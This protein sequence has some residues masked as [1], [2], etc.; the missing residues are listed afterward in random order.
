MRWIVL[1]VLGL[2][3]AA[4]TQAP[5][6]GGNPRLERFEAYV[7][8]QQV[9]AR[10]ATAV[11]ATRWA[12]R[13]Q[14]YTPKPP[15]RFAGR[16]IIAG[17]RGDPRIRGSRGSGGCNVEIFNQPTGIQLRALCFQQPAQQRLGELP[18]RIEWQDRYLVAR[19]IERVDPRLG[20]K[21]WSLEPTGQLTH[22][23]AHARTPRPASCRRR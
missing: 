9:K 10:F 17:V 6:R 1:L 19:I 14:G 22:A 11:N 15:K 8:A 16:T 12:L 23:C 13:A 3:A 4:C 5:L 18:A 20:E 2:S 21:I 7:D